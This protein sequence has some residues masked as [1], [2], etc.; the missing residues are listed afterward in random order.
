MISVCASPFSPTHKLTCG[1]IV[2]QSENAVNHKNIFTMQKFFLFS[3]KQ[4]TFF[5]ALARQNQS[6]SKFSQS[7]FLDVV[8]PVAP[9]F[10]AFSTSASVRINPPAKIGVSNF[11]LI[12]AII[13]G[14]APGNTSI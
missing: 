5:L 4:N 6:H 8:I 11:S 1:F 12:S 14:I 7:S 13:Q 9:A 3:K 10:N 2:R